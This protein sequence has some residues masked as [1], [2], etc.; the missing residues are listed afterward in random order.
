MTS[1]SHQRKDQICFLPELNAH[2]C[3]KCHT[4]SVF[5]SAGCSLHVSTN[6]KI[7]HMLV[8][9]SEVSETVRA[10]GGISYYNL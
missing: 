3:S 1:V 8:V 7:A 10:R 2:L 6:Y 4:R 9:Q 5:A